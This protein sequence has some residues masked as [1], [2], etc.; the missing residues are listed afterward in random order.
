MT[1][2][3]W[4]IGPEIE[5]FKM[6][7]LPSVETSAK[8]RRTAAPSTSLTLSIVKFLEGTFLDFLVIQS[9]LRVQKLQMSDRVCG[10]WWQG[11]ADE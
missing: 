2:R 10:A 9:V 11:A 1:L 4:A 6:R 5:P 8:Q 7:S 3:H